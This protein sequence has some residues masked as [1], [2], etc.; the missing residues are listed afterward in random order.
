MAIV[1]VDNQAFIEVGGSKFLSN[2]TSMNITQTFKDPDIKKTA[3]AN[4]SSGDTPEYKITIKNMDGKA[5]NAVAFTDALDA[6][7]HTFVAGS[8]K[9][10]GTAAVPGVANAVAPNSNAPFVTVPGTPLQ[11]ITAPLP[12]IAAGATVTVTFNVLVL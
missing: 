11:I 6:S 3:P 1:K 4:A 7:K 8:F 10:N 2:Q 9:V 5:M 12:S